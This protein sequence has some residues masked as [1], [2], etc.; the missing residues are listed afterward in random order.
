MED[1]VR[2]LPKEKELYS[3]SDI[4]QAYNRWYGSGL[5]THVYRAYKEKDLVK[6]E[7]KKKMDKPYEELQKM[8]GLT[9]VKKVVDEIL[10]TAKMQK[11]RKSM[12]LPKLQTSMH[13]LFSGNPGTA[14]TTVARLLAQVLKEE[15][16]LEKRAYCGMRPT[17]SGWK[18]CGMD[19]TDCGR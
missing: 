7:L 3:V 1:L 16:V 10:A 19:S 12:G 13:M 18:I 15:E 5:K 4:F 8:V 2:Y 9:D 6:I 11:M 17:G 14:K